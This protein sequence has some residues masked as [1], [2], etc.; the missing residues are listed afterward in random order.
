MKDVFYVYILH[1][2]N[3]SYYTGYTNNLEKRYQAHVNG[4]ASKYTRSF[5]PIKIAQQWEFSDKSSAMKVEIYIKKLSRAQKEALILSPSLL[6][7]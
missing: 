1:C 5:P 6:A 4:T 2:R 7:E 3:N